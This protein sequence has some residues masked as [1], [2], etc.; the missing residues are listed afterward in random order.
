MYEACKSLSGKAWLGKFSG[1]KAKKAIHIRISPNTG[2]DL[3]HVLLVG[4]TSTTRVRDLW[5]ILV[6]HFVTYT[7]MSY[8]V[9]GM[10]RSISHRENYDAR[11]C[12]CLVVDGAQG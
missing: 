5:G 10:A 8:C 9:Q 3:V 2:T 6:H 4:R 12:L 11:V 7:V 1:G